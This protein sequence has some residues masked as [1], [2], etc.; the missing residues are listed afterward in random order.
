MIQRTAGRVRQRDQGD[1]GEFAEQDVGHLAA[2]EADDAQRGEFAAAFRQRDA[3]VVVNHPKR[4][5]R[6]KAQID[7]LDQIDA[8][9]GRLPARAAVLS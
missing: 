8:R 2:A 5:H 3:R 9:G 1:H 6:G 4:H 7:R